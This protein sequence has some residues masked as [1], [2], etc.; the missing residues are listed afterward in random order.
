M[1]SS[2]FGGRVLGRAFVRH[3]VMVESFSFVG[4]KK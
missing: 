1:E 2:A 4:M 3:G